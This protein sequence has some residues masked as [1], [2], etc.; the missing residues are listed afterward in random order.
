M[1]AVRML[2]RR[3][4]FATDDV[5]IL[6][7]IPTLFHGAWAIVLLI[8]WLIIGR[9]K[10]C[11][12]GRGYSVVLGGLFGTFVLFFLLGCWA[13]YEGLKGDR[14]QPCLSCCVPPVPAKPANEHMQLQDVNSG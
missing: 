4:S 13:I 8:T 9:P 7:F 14:P 5:P 1:P 12:E 3:W 10:S 6:G 11:Y 2:G